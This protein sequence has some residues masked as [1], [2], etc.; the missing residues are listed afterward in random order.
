MPAPIDPARLAAFRASRDWSQDDLATAS[1]LSTRTVQRLESGE[2]ASLDTLRALAAAFAVHPNQL[3]QY[4][5]PPGFRWGLLGGL[6]GAVAG[7]GLAFAAL[8]SSG[9][10][11]Q[12]LGVFAGLWGAGLGGLCAVA[13]LMLNCD[14]KRFRT[15]HSAPLAN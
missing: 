12:T 8:A 9:A 1:G 14:R 5:Q 7:P 3:R 13:G 4:R 6:A 2:P 15:G 11:G 10:D